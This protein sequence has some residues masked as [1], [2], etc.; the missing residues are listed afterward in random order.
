MISVDV[1]D[2]VV[3]YSMTR[4]DWIFLG[5]N[6]FPQPKKSLCMIRL[7]RS[8]AFRV[9]L[10]LQSK[11]NGQTIPLLHVTLWILH[12]STSIT[13]TTYLD[14]PRW[15]RMAIH[16][17]L[18]GHGTGGPPAKKQKTQQGEPDSQLKLLSGEIFSFFAWAD[19]NYWFR[20]VWDVK[21]DQALWQL[22][23]CLLDVI[24]HP[25]S[26]I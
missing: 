7:E 21:I 2:H 9:A 23:L 24:Q 11:Y 13:S 6:I 8:F 16:S 25:R 26:D 19:C 22:E 12:E 20:P 10:Q 5:P 17:N 3:I 18:R 4:L 1:F 15:W 14:I